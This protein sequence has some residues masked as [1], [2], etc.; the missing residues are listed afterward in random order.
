MVKEFEFK[1]S[2]GIVGFGWWLG[3]EFIHSTEK[4]FVDLELMFVV[5]MR[6]VVCW[7]WCHPE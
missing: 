4:V 7:L 1:V 2:A 6:S 5:E 3:S